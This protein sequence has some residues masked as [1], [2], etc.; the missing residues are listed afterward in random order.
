ME[1]LVTQG[2]RDADYDWIHHSQILLTPCP[3]WL[4]VPLSCEKIVQFSPIPRK[5]SSER[6]FDG[7]ILGFFEIC[8]WL[9]PNQDKGLS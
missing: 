1:L 6:R 2:M 5:M 7:A 9:K 4:R 8:A 3:D